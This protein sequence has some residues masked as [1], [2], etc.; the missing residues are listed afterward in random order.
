MRKMLP[1]RKAKIVVSEYVQESDLVK[2]TL[3]FYDDSSEQTYVWPSIDLL[4][5]LNIKGRATSDQIINFC[6][7]MK[8]K[9]INFV[10]DEMPDQKKDDRNDDL[11]KSVGDALENEINIV[12]R[13]GHDTN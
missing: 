4:Q 3:F 8:D 5:C 13:Q 7:K 11:I 1:P 10:I 6:Q 12:E 2:W 9:D